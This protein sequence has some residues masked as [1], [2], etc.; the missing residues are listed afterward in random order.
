MKKKSPSKTQ[1]ILDYIDENP[2]MRQA[3]IAR[4][5][6][7]NKGRQISSTLA[8]LRSRGK[9][10]QDGGGY[11]ISFSTVLLFVPAIMDLILGLFVRINL[12]SSLVIS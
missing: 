9:I 2:G 6:G 11:Y 4:G 7:A 8:H 1:L 10:H 12:P 3:E 5:I